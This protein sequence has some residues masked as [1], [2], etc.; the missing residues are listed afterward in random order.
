VT[1]VV[2]ATMPNGKHRGTRYSLRLKITLL[3]LL[4]GLASIGVTLLVVQ[5]RLIATLDR[6]VADNARQ[7]MEIVADG[8]LPFMIQNQYAAIHENLDVLRE[9]Q[10]SWLHVEL[11]GEGNRRLYPLGAKPAP[12]GEDIR[13]FS[14]P[15]IFRGFTQGVLIAWID[16]HDQHREAVTEAHIVASIIAAT[17]LLTMFAVALSFELLVGRR[18]RALSEAASRM[19]NHDY[20]A[21][22]P[23]AGQD[24]IGNLVQSFAD[25]RNSVRENEAA[26]I[27][28]NQ[29]AQ[30]ANLA[31]SQFLATMSHELRTPMNGILGMSQLLLMPGCSPQEQQEYARTILNSGQS[32]LALLNDILDLSKVEAG[33]L[34]LNHAEVSPEQIMRETLALFGE[35]A[36]GKGLQIHVDWQGP[37]HQRYW[38]DPARLRQMLSNLVN[39]AIKF[40]DQGVIRI[41]GSAI[42][43]KGNMSRLTFAVTDSGIGIAADKQA[44]LFMPFSQVDSSANRKFSGTGL[45]LSIVRKLARLMGGEAGVESSLG[46]GSRFWFTVEV[47]MLPTETES[48]ACCQVT[49]SAPDWTEAARTGIRPARALIVED[50]AINRKVLMSQLGKLGIQV[51]SSENGQEAV[52]AIEAGLAPDLVLMDCRMPIMDGFDAT[53]RIR[54]WESQSGRSHLPIIAVTANAFLDDRERCLSVGM[55]DFLAK[56]VSLNDLRD[57]LAQW[58]PR[59]LRVVDSSLP[60]ESAELAQMLIE[61]DLVRLR[62]LLQEM[63]ELVS[64]QSFSAQR[65]L[66]ELE[67]ACRGTPFTQ[68]AGNL[69]QAVRQLDYPNALEQIDRW[70]KTMKAIPA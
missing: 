35:L 69:A 54:L 59:D 22:L 10:P 34:E 52:D 23:M 16:F 30:A 29:A 4:L 64:Q 33:K 5:P 65:C 9:R 47:A 42:A 6:H 13:Q 21:H 49:S 8:L 2:S 70:L 25:M 43:T 1:E 14:H 62:A 57:M 32:L 41:E 3:L 46:Q 63:Q 15:I 60:P 19:A 48:D 27:D 28:A 12:E 61:P 31:K 24:E 51:E 20:E 53:Q 40:T 18:T 17:F 11:I 55:D 7:Q 67:S 39:N 26:L 56:P 38:S 50:N 58:L 66:P 45:G 44:L 37:A 36:Q 68:A